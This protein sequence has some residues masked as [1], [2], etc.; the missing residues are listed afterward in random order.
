MMKEYS[1]IEN[2]DNNDYSM[3]IFKLC[4]IAHQSLR[5]WDT[6]AMGVA[7]MGVAVKELA[8]RTDTWNSLRAII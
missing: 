6:D 5:L 4:D 7:V 2:H 3:T 8:L 1:K